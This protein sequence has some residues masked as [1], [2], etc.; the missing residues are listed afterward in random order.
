MTIEWIDP[1]MGPTIKISS[2]TEEHKER[3]KRYVEIGKKENAEPLEVL[4]A[5]RYILR[6]PEAA[7]VIEHAKKLMAF[8]NLETGL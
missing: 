8:A 2:L 6:C 7:S 4:M 5:V 1:K 3:V